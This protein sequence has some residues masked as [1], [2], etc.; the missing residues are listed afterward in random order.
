MSTSDACRDC[1]ACC[2]SFRVAFYWT[3]GEEAGGPVP[4][5]YTEPLPP[6]RLC[7]AGTNTRAP[8]CAALV[9]EVGREVSCAIYAQRSSTCH[10]FHRHGEAGEDNPACTRARALHGLPPLGV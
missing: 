2:A 10:D 8:R 1:G 5:G 4:A 7:M 6:H 9:G 3:E